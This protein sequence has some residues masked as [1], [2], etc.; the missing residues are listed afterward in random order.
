MVV[1][2]CEVVATDD[3]GCSTDVRLQASNF[4]ALSKNREGS[5]GGSKQEQ[6]WAPISLINWARRISLEEIV[7]GH[8]G[9]G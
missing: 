7:G 4:V 2:R 8:C 3:K 1:R 9:R 6:R 5:D